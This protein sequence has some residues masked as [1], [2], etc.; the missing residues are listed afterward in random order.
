MKRRI[1]I[2][3]KA[4][5]NSSDTQQGISGTHI[6]FSLDRRGSLPLPSIRGAFSS[7]DIGFN[8]SFAD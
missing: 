1:Q 2:E 4:V 8:E 7:D 3:V 6:G 5:N